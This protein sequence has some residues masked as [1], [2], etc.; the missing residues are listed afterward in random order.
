[1]NKEDEIQKI[2]KELMDLGEAQFNASKSIE[3]LP[4]ADFI[5]LLKVISKTSRQMVLLKL[6]RLDEI[7]GLP[8][9]SQPGWFERGMKMMDEEGD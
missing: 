3:M 4:E 2:Y 7:G 5:K 6:K 9:K 1:M 8:Y